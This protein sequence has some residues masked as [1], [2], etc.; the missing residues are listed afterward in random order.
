L[1]AD[2]LRIISGKDYFGGVVLWS[3]GGGVAV[4]LLDESGGGLVDGLD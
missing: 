4:P 1:T 3:A 2:Y